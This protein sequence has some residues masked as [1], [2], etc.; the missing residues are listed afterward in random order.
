[1]HD[2]TVTY[3]RIGTSETEYRIY[4]VQRSYPSRVGGEVAEISDV[5]FRIGRCPVIHT[6]RI[7]K[8]AG[9][10][11]VVRSAIS[12]LMYVETVKGICRE[13]ADIRLHT[14]SFICLCKCN[15]TFSRVSFGW[16]NDR[17]SHL[18]VSCVVNCT[19]VHPGFRF[20]FGDMRTFLV[21]CLCLSGGCK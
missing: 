18:Y 1:M 7:V 9:R 13:T 8:A 21:V 5:A 19:G 12:I 2:H 10:C 4:V 3:D 16:M 15:D 20:D 6:L 14:D 17:R 11:T